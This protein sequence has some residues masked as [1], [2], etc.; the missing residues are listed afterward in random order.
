MS[1]RVQSLSSICKN[2]IINHFFYFIEP[3]PKKEFLITTLKG[4][5]S[6]KLG[7]EL[8][9]RIIESGEEQK[10]YL[11][12]NENAASGDGIF[13]KKIIMMSDKPI[14]IFD[15]E[16]KAVTGSVLDQRAI[17]YHELT[18][19]LQ[20]ITFGNELKKSVPKN[21]NYTE[22]LE[23][24]TISE[25]NACEQK[26]CETL[27]VPSRKNHSGCLFPPA[28]QM[29]HKSKKQLVITGLNYLFIGAE[30]DLMAIEDKFTD[31]EIEGWIC[32][33]PTMGEVSLDNLNCVQ[34]LIK[35]RNLNIDF[36]SE[37]FHTT[38]KFFLASCNYLDEIK[39]IEEIGF[40]L[41]FK[42]LLFHLNSKAFDFIKIIK[43][44]KEKYNIDLNLRND[45]GQTFFMQHSSYTLDSL[46][47]LEKLGADFTMKCN[48]KRT[49]LHSFVPEHRFE[50]NEYINKIKYLVEAKKIEINHQ[51]DCGNT[52]FMKHLTKKELI[53]LN[54][55]GAIFS[56]KNNENKNLIFFYNIFLK[57]ALESIT[58]LKGIGLYLFESDINGKLFYMNSKDNILLSNARKYKSLKKLIDLLEP[59]KNLNVMRDLVQYILVTFK[60]ADLII[61][62]MVVEKIIN[63]L[64]ERLDNIEDSGLICRLLNVKTLD[65]IKKLELQGCDFIHI[66]K[67]DDNILFYLNPQAMEYIKIIKYLKDKYALNINKK[68][69]K[70][71]TF[72]MLHSGHYSYKDFVELDRMGADLS[73][74]DLQRRNILFF[75]DST[76]DDFTKKVIFLIDQKKLDIN[77]TN[78]EGQ[79][80]FMNQSFDYLTLRFLR[81]MG[82]KFDIRTT[83]NQDNLLINYDPL[84]KDDFL[85]LFYLKSLDLNLNEYCRNGQKV[86]VVK[87]NTWD[88]YDDDCVPGALEQLKTFNELGIDLSEQYKTKQNFLFYLPSYYKEYNE[89]LD[90]LI[91]EKK[92]DINSQDSIGRKFFMNSRAS[93]R[94][95]KQIKKL[96]KLG[97][98]LK[99]KYQDDSSFIF[100]IDS[101][102]KDYEEMIKYLINTIGLD[103]NKQDVKGQTCFMHLNGSIKSMSQ[104]TFL[105]KMKA[106]LD[107]IDNEGKNILFYISP[108]SS[109]FLKIVEYLVKEYGIDIN[110]RDINGKIFCDNYIIQKRY[111]SELKELGARFGDT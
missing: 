58:Y 5:M 48:K 50:D 66:N 11:I 21:R 54:K 26:F 59:E 42:T 51:D 93:V 14:Y 68:N 20:W 90:Y 80:F 15:E 10:I 57:D 46:K 28:D 75:L 22:K 99:E 107:I 40:D 96:Q 70:G 109:D 24:T 47:E 81:Q 63:P 111:F 98:N 17:L 110:K 102:F 27:T 65:E 73:L 23:E 69:K 79:T 16:K 55:L 53:E 64:S 76:N 8:I 103:I 104:L 106:H 44:L 29:L 37:K 39:K 71:V 97:V 100:Y 72:F 61:A 49:V 94:N 87:G 67:E 1:N 89:M 31:N 83:I 4:V 85:S 35:K 56:I 92:M 13:G 18:H 43:Y 19:Q 74:K 7:V 33:L 41:S 45:D 78:L 36:K 30:N 52:F 88:K 60:D 108:F 34:S 84:K 82:A 32:L 62:N 3:D 77:E 6:E 105:K 25:G 91:N 2:D 12:S 101:R 9:K 95:L 38:L 86:Y